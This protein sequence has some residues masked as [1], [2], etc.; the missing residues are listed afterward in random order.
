MKKYVKRNA[1]KQKAAKKMYVPHLI[2]SSMSGVTRPMMKLH[3]HVADVV[4]EMALERMDR[5]KISD[6]RTHPIGAIPISIDV[7][8]RGNGV[9]VPKE[10]EKLIS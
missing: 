8:E 10:Y 3:I 2:V 6:G 9:D 5:L 1:I 4:I 7:Q